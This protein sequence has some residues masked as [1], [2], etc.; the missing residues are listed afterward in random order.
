[1]A[2]NIKKKLERQGHNN[3]ECEVPAAHAHRVLHADS[4]AGGGGGGKEEGSGQQQG[5]D[6]ADQS[7]DGD[8]NIILPGLRHTLVVLTTKVCG[9]LYIYIYVHICMCVYI[10]SA[11]QCVMSQSTAISAKSG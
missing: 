3:A 6:A 7:A 8:V 5:S 1:M 9:Y 4:A 11:E 10:C 2:N